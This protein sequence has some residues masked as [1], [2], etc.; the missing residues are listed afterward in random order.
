MKNLA[1]LA[2]LK[3]PNIVQLYCSYTYRDKYNLIFAVADHGSLD[4]LFRS[5]IPPAIALTSRLL[6]ALAELASG[7]D[8]LHNFASKV[9]DLSLSGCHHDLAPRNILVHGE[10]LLLADFG[11]STFHEAEEDSLTAFREVRG[12]YIAPECQHIQNNRVETRT[13]GRASDIWSFGCVISEVLTYMVWG[14][15]GVELFRKA[16]RVEITPEL[17]WYRF[18]KGPETP[19]PEVDRWLEK[20]MADGDVVKVRLVVLIRRMLSIDPQKRPLST[21]VWVTL[22]GIAVLSIA[23]TVNQLLAT[24]INIR[25]EGV[26]RFLFEMQFQ[27]WLYGFNELLDGTR[28]SNHKDLACDFPTMS[29]ALSELLCSLR[30]EQYSTSDAI[31]RQMSFFKYQQTRL[32]RALPLRHRTIA[33]DHLITLIMGIPDAHKLGDLSVALRER[34]ND[35]VG[36][37]VAVRCLTVLAESGQLIEQPHLMLDQR[38]ITLR[39]DNTGDWRA[40][41]TALM[42]SSSEP[43]L[44][45]RLEYKE[46]HAQAVVGLEL[47][48]RLASI[49]NLLH[50]ESSAQIPGAPRCRGLYH[51]PAHRAFG[52]VYNIP[53]P[54]S[55]PIDLHRLIAHGDKSRPPLEFRFQLAYDICRCIFAFH[56][57]GWLHRRL[58][59]RNVFFFPQIGTHVAEQAKDPQVL[60]FAASREDQ[61]YSFTQGPEE[62]M[63]LWIYQHP[64]YLSLYSRFRKEFDY[65]SLGMI[66]LEIGFW[67]TLPNLT[68]SSQF[69]N[70]SHQQ[71]RHEV[72]RSRVSQLRIVM[73]TRYMVAVQRCLE[74][75]F[76][77]QSTNSNSQNDICQAFKQLV[78]DQLLQII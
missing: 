7:L 54:D 45:E 16:R 15:T 8:A 36:I 6:P 41:T 66:L 38:D 73:G 35:E 30:S 43:V 55:A 12:A 37:L 24:R 68:K 42:E 63:D 51:D 47:R 64:E 62:D 26:G 13:V 14:A 1:L 77:L 40:H 23:N 31:P 74:G 4:A 11:L 29:Q 67:K 34:G 20:L 9:Y 60:G 58:H 78:V 52:I 17:E 49:V 28:S 59:S 44:V 75:G 10:T 70:I 25:G 56:Q 21:E 18:H 32:S 46:I 57:V 76:G 72:I 50:H 3:H 5:R 39:P 71:F 22:R 19:N 27:S 61:L 53:H 48:R 2:H 33:E 69:R 65:Y